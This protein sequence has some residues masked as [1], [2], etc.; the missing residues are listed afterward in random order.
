MIPNGSSSISLTCAT[1]WY[2]SEYEI[3]TPV[4]KIWPI[5]EPS[6]VNDLIWL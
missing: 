3:E 2:K 5:I 1:I 4:V 6:E